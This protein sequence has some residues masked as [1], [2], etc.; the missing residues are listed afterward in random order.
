MTIFANNRNLAIKQF[1][2][3]YQSRTG[4]RELGVLFMVCNLTCFRLEENNKV[5]GRD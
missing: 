2:L 5:V 4:S 1:G 3:N